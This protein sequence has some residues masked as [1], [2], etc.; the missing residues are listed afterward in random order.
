MATNSDAETLRNMGLAIIAMAVVLAG[1]VYGSTFLIPLAFA[2]LLWNLLEALIDGL[3]RISLG[4]H[5]VPGWLAV[6]LAIAVIGVFLYLVAVILLGQA[7]AIAAAWPRYEARVKTL[8][9]E[10]A[11]WLGP[12]PSA[13]VRD[14]LAKIDTFAQVTGLFV[15]VQ[16]FVLG[17]VLVFLYVGFLLAES[18]FIRAKIVALFPA[19]DRANDVGRVL[20]TISGGVRRYVW[21]KTLVSALTGGLSYVIL[22]VIGVDF[23]ETW[24]LLIFLLNYIPNV[25]SVLGVA[26]PAL[27]ALV[28]FTTLGPF[29]AI[30]IGLASVQALIGNVVEPM[31]MGRSLNM[32]SFAIVLALTF[33]GTIWGLVG[34]FLSVPIMVLVMIVCANVPS[35]RW[36]A[37]L[38]SKDGQIDSGPSSGVPRA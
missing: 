5:R 19:E 22:R 4:P 11:Q 33:W 9:N 8:I 3:G 24:G 15:T 31:L 20:T 14:E 13:K 29:L 35:W 2:V 30:A 1:L 7:D 38:L 6:V 26:F 34:M 16:S 32:S 21:I 27:L 18:G 23:A 37:L 12:A 17:L 10:W 36:V 25:G 28:Q